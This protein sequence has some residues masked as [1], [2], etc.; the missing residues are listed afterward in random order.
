MDVTERDAPAHS[1][2][3]KGIGEE[4]TDLGG[5]GEAGGQL[6]GI[7]RLWAPPGDGDLLPIPGAS[8]IG[9]GRIL[10]G[11]GQ[12]FFMGEGGVEEDDNNPHQGGGVASGVRIFL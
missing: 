2:V 11:G 4:V 12:E 3:Q 8:D 7:Q 9:G 10:A 6:Q 1:V 5:R